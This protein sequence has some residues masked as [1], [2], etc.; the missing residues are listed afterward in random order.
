MKGVVLVLIIACFVLSSTLGMVMSRD[1]GNVDLVTA[2]GHT[3]IP[4]SLLEKARAFPDE[5]TRVII[6]FSEKPAGA[7]FRNFLNSLDSNA[8]VVR[9]F[10]IIK[11]VAVSLPARLVERLAELEG[12]ISIREDKRVHAF[13]SETIPLVNADDAWLL[14]YNGSGKTVCIVDTGIDYTHPALTGKV[15]AQHCYCLGNS[16]PRGCCPNNNEE[17]TNAMD[18][19]GHGTHVAGIVA[20]ND[21]TYMGVAPGVDLMAVKVL[22]DKGE[23]YTSDVI[24]GIDWCSGQ[25][26]DVITISIGSD[27]VVYPQYCYAVYCDN[28]ADSQA[29]NNA[30][31]AGAV[32]TIATGNEHSTSLISSPACASKVIAVGA[33][34][35]SDGVAGFTNR[36]SIMDLLAPGGTLAGSHSCP[37]GNA[38]CSAQLGGGFIGYSGTS[39]A[40]P[41]VAGVAALLLG[42]KP[43]LTPKQVEL[44]M[45]NTGVGI[46]D[47]GTGLTFPRLDVLAAASLPQIGHLEPYLIDPSPSNPNPGKNV[48]QNEFFSFRSGVKCVGGECGNVSALL[49]SVDSLSY[50]DGTPDVFDNASAKYL[51]WGNPGGG[52][53]IR[54]TPSTYPVT[55]KT[56]SFYVSDTTPFELHVWD[57]DGP[58]GSPG[59]D[60]LTAF[61]VNPAVSEDWFDV[62]LLSHS[63]SISSGDFYIGWIELASTNHVGADTSAPYDNRTWVYNES[64]WDLLF[65]YGSPYEAIDMMIRA[66]VSMLSTTPGNIP[67]YTTSSNPQTCHSMQA[68]D[69][70][71]QTW[72]VN[73]TGQTN[74]TWEFST[75][76]DSTAYDWYV[77]TNVTEKANVSIVEGDPGEFISITL[78]GYPIG[79]GS[80]DH[81][82]TDNPATG[83]SGG[84]GNLYTITIEP[85]T[86][87]NVNVY[88]KGGDFV[89]GGSSF[90]IGNMTWSTVN[91]AN[92]SIP[93]NGTYDSGYPVAIDASPG[94]NITMYYWLDV[95]VG[96]TAGTY[97]APLYIKALLEE[98]HFSLDTQATNRW[99]DVYGNLTIAGK[100]AMIWDELAAFDPDNVLCGIFR[101][102]SEGVYG[103]L[104]I[105]G[106]DTVYT[107]AID[108]GAEPGD[109]ITFKAYDWSE[110]LELDATGSVFWS[111]YDQVMLDLSA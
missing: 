64:A 43:Y 8:R 19:D 66:D 4:E 104:H 15:V 13:L 79:F 80:L 82:T 33:T 77:E 3:P 71:N 38:V 92:T 108:E 55:I 37:T 88:Q 7:G 30:V 101:V 12:V 23:G 5:M 31:D 41:H 22:D 95:P 111:E 42:A 83:N 44:I 27:C 29:A 105:Y 69:T 16:G 56:A 2:T 54:F 46:Y 103:F 93:V 45:E 21:S 61:Q 26:A 94:T 81:G 32:V 78:N 87:V 40:T 60:L 49:D 51:G 25:G 1:V 63:I 58:G 68:G 17:D 67:F 70:C 36:N 10:N 34:T 73:A 106:D 76:Y 98:T 84:P 39:M 9:D 109:E 57:D 99:M 89:N 72:N 90:S 11:G 53:A 59:T 20:S 18:D 107:P 62:D 28:E 85:E 65:N 97:S 48:T 86:T 47:S 52:M 100:P 6:T 91:N 110:D 24:A 14:G 96:K 75:A 35:K 50:D 102:K 74:T